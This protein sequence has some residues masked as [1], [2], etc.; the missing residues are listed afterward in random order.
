M[1]AT[2]DKV[3][4]IAQKSESLLENKSA[5]KLDHLP[6]LVKQPISTMD[7]MKP[8]KVKRD[9]RFKS[10]VE[11]NNVSQ[12][13]NHRPEVVIQPYGIMDVLKPKPENGQAW[14]C[15]YDYQSN[16]KPKFS[17]FSIVDVFKIFALK[18]LTSAMEKFG[19]RFD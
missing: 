8:R 5:V 19:F 6:E 16:P 3:D 10:L 2:D 11:N 17:K 14:R 12:V 18:I 7:V 15:A 1:A 13:L 4:R 9:E